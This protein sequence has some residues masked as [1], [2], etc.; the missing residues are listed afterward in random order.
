MKPISEIDL[1]Q[2]S[3]Y[4]DGELSDSERRFFQKRLSCDAELRACCERVWIASSVL[5]SQPLQ[6]MPKNNAELIG[7]K[8]ADRHSF[9]ARP[10]RLV[11]S[12]GALAIV[13]GIGFQLMKS[14]EAPGLVA[15]TATPAVSNT[16][17]L[18]VQSSSLQLT[19]N[20]PDAKPVAEK[21]STV[22]GSKPDVDS[23]QVVSQSDP[24]QFLLNET[25]RSKSWPRSTQGMDDYVAR[26]NQM[27]DANS[28]NGLISYAQILTD[29]QQTSQQKGDQ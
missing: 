21:P 15:Q 6:L 13:A 4:I 3:A 27:A 14:T 25:T 28:S 26:H 24:S 1:E 23:V 19:Q 8:C 9:F 20:T 10:M 11:A 2:I 22:A 18:V 12:F 17:G 5:K 16:P 7:S 29:E